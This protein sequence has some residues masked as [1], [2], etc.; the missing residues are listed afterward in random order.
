MFSH[1]QI[2]QAIDR[3]AEANG[4]SASGLARA[5]GLDATAFN[6]SKRETPRGRPRWPTTESVAKCLAV[7]RT[8]LGDFAG[9]VHGAKR[10]QRSVPSIDIVQAGAPDA[11]D[12]AGR[13]AG[14]TWNRINLPGIDDPCAYALRIS[15]DQLKPVYRDGDMVIVSPAAVVRPGDRVVVKTHDGEVLARRLNRDTGTALELACFNPQLPLLTLQ[16]DDIK[17]MAR[18]VWTSQ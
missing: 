3:L 10:M 4:M 2:W 18:I 6:K 7:T 1:S 9:L 16:R 8:S 11:F 12:D 5:A 17:W 15:G 13:P 14:N